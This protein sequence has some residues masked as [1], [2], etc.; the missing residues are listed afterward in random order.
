MRAYFRDLLS[1]QLSLSSTCR[2]SKTAFEPKSVRLCGECL[3]SP[4][5][6]SIATYLPLSF[7]VN[8]L[9]LTFVASPP[10]SLI[11]AYLSL[12]FGLPLPVPF[13]LVHSSL[14][15]SLSLSLLASIK[16]TYLG[17]AFFFFLHISFPENTNHR[18]K[19]SCT[20]D[21]LFD[22][23]GFDQPTKTFFIFNISKAAESKPN[24]QEVNRIVIP[25]SL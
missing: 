22:W 10:G 7:L 18:G 14:L 8:Q 16:D 13:H 9:L 12:S 23:C 2:V 4:P 21:L 20:P 5:P 1:V 24:K 17:H 6:T 11:N 15:F 25:T 19:Y 3:T